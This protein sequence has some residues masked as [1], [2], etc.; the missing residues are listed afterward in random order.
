MLTQYIS[1]LTT[2]QKTEV[3]RRMAQLT[4][5]PF[6]KVEAT[7][8]TEVGYHGRDVD[9]II[10]DLMD[11]SMQL[12]R[13]LWTERLKKEAQSK[14]EERILDLLTGPAHGATA[15]SSPAGRD[16]FRD[17]LQQGL[18]DDQEIEVD[19]PQNDKNGDMSVGDG[20][21]PNVVVMTNLFQSMSGQGKKH[22]T[23]RKKLTIAAAREVILQ[24]E[25][26]KLLEQVDL[27]KE[28]IT[29]VEESGIVF[30]D[31]IGMYNKQERRA[32]YMLEQ[33]LIL[34]SCR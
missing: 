12:T 8:F 14:V 31:E 22:N 3:A 33:P 15:G 6:I 25:L 17:M 7:K 24:I 9:Q 27:K 2:L 11:V 18:L 21:N 30:I 26:D 1:I 13:K 23:E 10:R 19:V 29:A 20:S 4:E 5:A 32:V 28:A 16:S 34:F